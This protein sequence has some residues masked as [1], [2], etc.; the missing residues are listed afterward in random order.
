MPLEVLYC[1]EIHSTL[2]LTQHH[3][4]SSSSS[5]FKVCGLPFEY[6][7]FGP[8]PAKCVEVNGSISASTVSSAA[9]ANPEIQDTTSAVTVDETSTST[10]TLQDT[11]TDKLSK[12]KMV[13]DSKEEGHTTITTTT[14]SAAAEG[15][16]VAAAPPKKKKEKLPNITIEVNNRNKR[17]YVTTVSGLEAFGIKLADA[18]K[19][20]A[21]KFSCG[22]SVVKNASGGEEIDIQGDFADDLVDLILDNWPEV[23]ETN[24][25]VITDKKKKR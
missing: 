11:T 20:M 3:T 1:K 12:L 2:L 8:S 6:C 15:E 13:D 5:Y 16:S 14:N 4:S 19:L 25:L 24:I 18:K 9:T 10:T 22:C 7:E 23:P 17:K 21:K